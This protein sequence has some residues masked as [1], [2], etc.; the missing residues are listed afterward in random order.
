TYVRSLTLGI[1]IVFFFIFC[2]QKIVSSSRTKTTKDGLV[3]QEEV[4]N[5]ILKNEKHT[6]NFCIR[7][8]TP[9][10]IS[11]TY[12]YLFLYAHMNIK[13][14]IPQT[15]WVNKT[16][17]FIMENDPYHFRLNEWKKIHEPKDQAT[18]TKK[19]FKDVVVAHYEI[20]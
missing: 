20:Q 19:V 7:V 15:E 12:N 2:I 10:V 17:W 5:F 11:Y 4:V 14:S 16:C 18:I 1:I 9:P 3:V 8:Y 13:T 6:N